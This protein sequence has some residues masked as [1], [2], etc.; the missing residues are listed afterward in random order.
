MTP[1]IF[2]AND[3]GRHAEHTTANGPLGVFA[4]ALLDLWIVQRSLRIWNAE[5]PRKV[6]DYSSVGN[7]SAVHEHSVEHHFYGAAIGARG[8][9]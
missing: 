3:E 1:E 8:N 7:V 6:S 2:I 9:D 4:Q 5:L